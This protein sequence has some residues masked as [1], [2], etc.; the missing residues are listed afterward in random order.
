MRQHAQDSI[1]R[2]MQ[3]EISDYRDDDRHHQRVALIGARAGNDS[4]KRKVERI[5]HRHDKL[6]ETRGAA[7]GH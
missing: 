4:S 2:Q 6:N 5:R 3:Q 1:D 7:R